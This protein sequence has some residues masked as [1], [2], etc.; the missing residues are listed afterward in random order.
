M[1]S[2]KRIILHTPL[3]QALQVV[4]FQY[5]TKLD[6]S[7]IYFLTSKSEYSSLPLSMV[8][9]PLFQLPVVNQDLEADDPPSNLS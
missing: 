5:I 3:A 4:Y 2:L 6:L 9:P 8:S 7:C 1:P